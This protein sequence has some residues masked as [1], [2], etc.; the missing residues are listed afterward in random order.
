MAAQLYFD[1]TRTIDVSGESGT[2]TPP[3][4][5]AGETRRSHH[6]VEFD[7][8]YDFYKE[9]N[10]VVE[11]E[12]I[13]TMFMTCMDFSRRPDD[14]LC[15]SKCPC[16]LYWNRAREFLSRAAARHVRSLRQGVRRRHFQK[17][18]SFAR[19]TIQECFNVQIQRGMMLEFD[20]WGDH[21]LNETN[22]S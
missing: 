21:H 14:K 8:T 1:S 18:V 5:D 17:R 3:S 11:A 13:N 12:A 16:R 15:C 4:S 19:P 20:I 2:D 10:E 7:D 9:V 6:A 22:M